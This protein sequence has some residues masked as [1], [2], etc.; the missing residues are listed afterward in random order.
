MTRQRVVV[1]EVKKLQPGQ[2]IDVSANIFGRP[3]GLALWLQHM[4]EFN[5]A[6]RVLENIVGSGYEY[7]Y[8]RNDSRDSITFG[9]LDQ[10]YTD[11]RRSYVSPDRRDRYAKRSDYEWVPRCS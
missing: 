5:D 10:P 4:T 6:D 2:R 9:R 8:R 1:D 11:G 7:W 3:Q